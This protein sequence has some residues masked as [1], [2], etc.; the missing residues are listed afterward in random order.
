MKELALT[1]G[2]FP[3]NGLYYYNISINNTTSINT[4]YT[5]LD[6]FNHYSFTTW[7]FIFIINRYIVSS[8]FNSQDGKCKYFLFK[9]T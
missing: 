5:I 9:R 4:K 3:L 8:L 7:F 6:N 1:K 2:R